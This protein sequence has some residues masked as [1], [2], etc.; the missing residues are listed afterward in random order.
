MAGEGAPG[1]A[2]PPE[3]GAARVRGGSG[4]DR[5]FAARLVRGS[6][7]GVHADRVRRRRHDAACGDGVLRR[8]DDRGVHG[9]D[10]RAFSDARP[11]G[12][13]LLGSLQ[14][15]PGQ[16]QGQGGRVDAVLAGVADAGHRGDP[17]AQRAGEGA[18]GTGEPDAPG[19]AGEGDAVARG[20]RHEGGQRVP[21]GVHG[22]LQS[23]LR[24]NAAQPGGRAPRGGARRGGAGP[25]PVRAPRTQ[26]DEEPDDPIRVPRVP[27]DGSGQGVPSTRRGGD[28]VQGLR[29]LGEGAARRARAGRAV[30]RRR[31]G[32]GGGGRR[33]DGSAASGGGQGGAAVAAREQAGAGPSLRRAS[34]PGA[35]GVCAG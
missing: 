31:R 17:R 12:G 16:R 6:R 2:R 19:P 30:A 14:R 18:R 22:G 33:E 28:G 13:V 20:G 10:A 23:A 25:G 27:G 21:A 15:V 1:G 3:P 26:A 29:R 8:G 7:S 35:T 4:A 11:A 32:G 34:K 24:G 9:D 5:R